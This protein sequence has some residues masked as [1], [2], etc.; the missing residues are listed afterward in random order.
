[1]KKSFYDQSTD[2]DISRFKEIRKLTTEQGE[3]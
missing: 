3:D 2:S 1:M